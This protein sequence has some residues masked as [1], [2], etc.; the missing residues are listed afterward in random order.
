M[1]NSLDIFRRIIM[2]QLQILS[3]QKPI[4]FT[5]LLVITCVGV[6][7]C[8][9]LLNIKDEFYKDIVSSAIK[10]VITF[11]LLFMLIKFNWLKS[12]LIT[13]PFK[14]WHSKW[15]LASLPMLLIAVLNLVSLDWSLLEFNSIKFLGWMYTNISTG[16]F[17][18]ILLRGVCLSVLYSA[19]KHKEKGLMYAAICQAVIFGLAHYV[20]LTK[21]PFL[22]VSVQ[23][24]YATLI[25]IGF[26]G[27]VAYS[28]SLWPAIALHSIINAC[29]SINN[30]FQPNFIATDMSFINYAIIIVIIALICAL[31]GVILLR[32]RQSQLS[33]QNIT[34][35]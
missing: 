14:D 7:Y 23:V 30:F 21:A 29:G 9:L 17:E 15:W 1:Q 5:L 32:K 20:N 26:A 18:E 4:L 34:A 22:E 2:Y 19:W 8:S 33:L 31:P 6:L 25:G 12:S 10:N 11:A 24:A 16:L 27:L 28:R 35:V 13:I 3:K